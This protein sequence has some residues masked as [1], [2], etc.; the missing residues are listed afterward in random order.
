MSKITAQIIIIF[1]TIIHL[2]IYLFFVSYS[3]IY[4]GLR[5]VQLQM[6]MNSLS[7]F[8]FKTCI[9]ADQRKKPCIVGYW[10]HH[11]EEAK[12]HARWAPYFGGRPQPYPGITIQHIFPSINFVS[13]ESSSISMQA[14][15]QHWPPNIAEDAS[16]NDRGLMI[17]WFYHP[18][19]L[20]FIFH[21]W[22]LFQD[23]FSLQIFTKIE[24]TFWSVFSSF[25]QPWC[26]T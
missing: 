26:S 5:Q 1:Y 7:L 9:V 21:F 2:K 20:L 16:L 25:I 23:P 4:V 6:I 18:D 3:Q 11:D 24:V 17:G 22:H 8:F 10:Q 14:F 12:K 15:N 19:C 13:F